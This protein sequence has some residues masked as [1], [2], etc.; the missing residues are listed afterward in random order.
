MAIERKGESKV[1]DL[2]QESKK[3]MQ[4]AQ[5]EGRPAAGIEI[6][7]G[8]GGPAGRSGLNKN[9]ALG[10]N[11]NG[12][13]DDLER[14]E[15]L[16]SETK[17][18]ER[19]GADTDGANY[20]DLSDYEHGGGARRND[21]DDLRKDDEGSDSSFDGDIKPSSGSGYQYN[22]IYEN[23]LDG[24]SGGINPLGRNS[25]LKKEE[26]EEEDPD[27]DPEKDPN[28]NP[29]NPDEPHGEGGNTG[30][31]PDKAEAD[32]E[33]LD[34][35]KKDAEAAGLSSDDIDH[36][37]EAAKG[38]D[39]KQQQ[40]KDPEEALNEQMQENEEKNQEKLEREKEK[41]D[42]AEKEEEEK[43]KKKDEEEKAK[44]E[45]TAVAGGALA[46]N[47]S[48]LQG[49]QFGNGYG[50]PNQQNKMDEINRR[51]LEHNQQMNKGNDED[52]FGT[53]K[54]EP[55]KAN[56]VEPTGDGKA[57]GKGKGETKKNGEGK[58]E[59]GKKKNNFMGKAKN[60]ID[61]AKNVDEW[62]HNPGR[63]EKMQ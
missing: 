25:E 21:F 1:E 20:S 40:N 8:G 16:G 38:Y 34:Q 53:P 31:D 35:S 45:G 49:N 61:K 17:A 22:G 60:T 13:S 27:K 28:E 59:P 42:A 11:P 15:G 14:D 19:R 51:N 30:E 62:I 54:G 24:P 5:R 41:A 6:R 29:E 50:N 12:R 57:E 36:S 18:P 58:A 44:D 48:A 46:S 55:P 2:S 7:P 32:K 47:P 63:M 39:E 26:K 9:T 3:A 52:R 10:Y 43:K 56:K 37:M 23:G 4:D 33:L